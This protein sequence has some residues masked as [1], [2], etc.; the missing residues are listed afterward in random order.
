MTDPR[1]VTFAVLIAAGIWILL[2]A[3]WLLRDAAHRAGTDRARRTARRT[4]IV[5]LLWAAGAVSLAAAVPLSFPVFLPMAAVPIALGTIA[6]L[7]PALSELLAHVRLAP[8]IA[9][10][11]YRNAGAIFLYL[12][13]ATGSLSWGFARNAGW[14]DVAT[15]VLA[16]PVAW[17]VWRRMPLAPAAVVLWCL[18]GIAD[19]IVAPISAGLYGAE[20]LV[21]FPINTVPLFL[22]PPLGILLQIMVLRA[23]WL[24]QGGGRQG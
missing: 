10:Q 9:V 14:G 6:A 2:A 21:A 24:Q 22:G 11:V 4:T 13:Y 3:A 17:M 16:L 20:S 19:L 7:R 15:G 23:W 1:T 5:L 18:L 12:F 8:L